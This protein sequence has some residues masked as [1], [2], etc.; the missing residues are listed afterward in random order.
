MQLHTLVDETLNR[1][2]EY[3]RGWTRGRLEITVWMFL[4]GERKQPFPSIAVFDVQRGLFVDGEPAHE[5]PLSYIA[6]DPPPIF[7]ALPR[8]HIFAVQ[9]RAQADVAVLCRVQGD[10]HDLLD[11]PGNSG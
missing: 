1:V 10:R 9:A 6:I 11:T 8:P 2:R 7:I 3:A 4:Q 5:T